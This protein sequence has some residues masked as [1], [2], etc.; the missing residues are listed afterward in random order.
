MSNQGD[1]NRNVSFDKFLNHQNYKYINSL[2]KAD[3][4]VI[5]K[6]IDIFMASGQFSVNKFSI[7]QTNP[8]K[9]KSQNFFSANFDDLSLHQFKLKTWN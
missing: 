5:W 7:I 4:I 6:Y 1:F 2:T 8:I 3:L 9:G